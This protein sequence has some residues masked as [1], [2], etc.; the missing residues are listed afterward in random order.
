MGIG[1]YP[2]L[3]DTCHQI[4]SWGELRLLEIS[5]RYIPV[6]KNVGGSFKPPGLSHSDRMVTS[7]SSVQRD[8]SS[9]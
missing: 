5:S 3:F 1:Q 4:L 2:Y 8:L 9:L 6:R 7:L